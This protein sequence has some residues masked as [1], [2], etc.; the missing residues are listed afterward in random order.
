[1]SHL[2]HQALVSA[3]NLS[4]LY[5]RIIAVSELHGSIRRCR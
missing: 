2:R 4:L 5:S 1:M 3:A